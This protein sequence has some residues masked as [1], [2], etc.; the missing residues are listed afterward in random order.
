MPPSD[1]VG[2]GIFPAMLHKGIF[3]QSTLI[4]KANMKFLYAASA[5][6]LLGQSAE[7]SA[8]SLRALQEG[9]GSIS[10]SMAG[11][12]DY[13]WQDGKWSGGGTS[14]SGKWSSKASKSSGKSGKSTAAPTA[15]DSVRI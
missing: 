10:M 15:S 7:A 11:I 4:I 14:G 9:Y 6:L 12:S 13:I 8:G 3:V 2:A 1:F 5:L